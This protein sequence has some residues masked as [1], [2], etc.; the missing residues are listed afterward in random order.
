MQ[1]NILG[2]E[3]QIINRNSVARRHNSPLMWHVCRLG[4]RRA[5]PYIVAVIITFGIVLY[6]WL[7]SIYADAHQANST[8]SWHRVHRG[9]TLISIARTTHTSVSKLAQANHITNT[10][11]IYNGQELCIPQKSKAAH[12]GQ[13]TC[14]H[15][16]DTN[17]KVCWYAYGS[18]QYSTQAQVAAELRQAADYYGLPPNLLLAIAWQESGWNQHIIAHDGGIG[19][20]QIMPYTAQVL[21]TEENTQLNPYQLHGNIRL[22]AI[23]LH[24]LWSNFHGDLN[25]VISAYNEGGWNVAH[26]GIFNWSYVNNVMALMQRF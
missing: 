11:Y 23:Y 13:T 12:S 18:L 2:P 6:N 3:Q 8:C 14:K 10:N 7:P 21:N 25:N 15:G 16:M 19:A 5:I 4:N 1:R 24:T 17:G 9:E 22:G 26:R 20:M